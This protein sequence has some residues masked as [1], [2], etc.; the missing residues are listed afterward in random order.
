MD[1]RCIHHLR[2]SFWS[3]SGTISDLKNNYAHYI[4]NFID[5]TPYQLAV[6]A[7]KFSFEYLRKSCKILLFSNKLVTKIRSLFYTTIGFFVYPNRKACDRCIQLEP[8]GSVIKGLYFGRADDLP[9]FD[10]PDAV[11]A[12][13]DGF[14][15]LRKILILS[16][17]TVV[18]ITDRDLFL[19]CVPL[20]CSVF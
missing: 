16:R 12:V 5:I 11:S 7:E 9:G 10:I 14:Q 13:A 3:A 6:F 1:G 20:S 18:A 4:I 15:L 19:Y 2:Y 17:L 8:D